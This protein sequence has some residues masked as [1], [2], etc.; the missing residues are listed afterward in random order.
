MI[1]RE[2]QQVL[3]LARPSPDMPTVSAPEIPLSS[4]FRQMT[5]QCSHLKSDPSA[6]A[7]GALR[8]MLQD[9]SLLID[10]FHV[11]Q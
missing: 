6:R 11:I 8:I 7:H 2:S 3:A 4:L 5:L 10:N 1:G 9:F